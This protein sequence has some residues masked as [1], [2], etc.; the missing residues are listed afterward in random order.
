MRCSQCPRPAVLASGPSGIP[1]CVYCHDVV[2]R[3]S[4]AQTE[5]FER[6]MNY[7]HSQAGQLTGMPQPAPFP[8]KIAVIDYGEK[9]MNNIN[10]HNSTVGVV[11]SGT[12]KS[13]DVAITMLKQ[14][15]DTEIAEVLRALTQAVV[16]SIELETSRKTQ[17]LQ[18]LDAVA[19][20]AAA[21]NDRRRPAMVRPLM[22]ELA[23]VVSG[24]A[25]LEALAAK[26]L[27]AIIA[28]FA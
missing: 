4:L 24:V 11:N 27:P 1:L 26:Y 9:V 16:D 3:N 20:E 18:L 15:G 21:P 17:A 13:V 7:L 10:I 12:I 19:A 8:E 25:A 2:M 5:R 6:M 23:N 28:C 14:Q 22:L